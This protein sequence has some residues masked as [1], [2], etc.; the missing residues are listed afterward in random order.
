MK[1]TKIHTL[2]LTLIYPCHSLQTGTYQN[3]L[4]AFPITE[5]LTKQLT[6]F[7]ICTLPDDGHWGTSIGGN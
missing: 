1:G 5:V 6:H 4:S 2:T 7:Q 3:T